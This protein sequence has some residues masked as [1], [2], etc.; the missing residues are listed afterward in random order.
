MSGTVEVLCLQTPICDVIIGKV[1]GARRAEDPDANH[2]LAGVV[3]KA[4]ER[5][6]RDTV[7]LRVP[8]ARQLVAIDRERLMQLQRGDDTIKK[9]RQFTEPKSKGQQ[10]VTYEVKN[11]ILY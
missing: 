4:K 2:H 7:P 11:D 6:G 9:Y 5:L 3:T 1:P 8:E 10:V